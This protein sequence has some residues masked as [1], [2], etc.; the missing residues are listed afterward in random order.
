MGSSEAPVPVSSVAPV[1]SSSV[2]LVPSSSVAPVPS[3]SGTP[4]SASSETLVPAMPLLP[5]SGGDVFAAV[6]PLQG[7]L[8]VLRRRRWLGEWILVLSLCFCFPFLLLLL[9]SFF[10]NFQA[11]IFSCFFVD[12]LPALCCATEY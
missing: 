3:S 10:I 7:P 12:F 8:F 2:A 6:V 4:I 11:F 5:P 1:L 9:A